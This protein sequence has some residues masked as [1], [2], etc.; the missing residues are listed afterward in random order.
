MREFLNFL[1]PTHIEQVVL[2]AGAWLGAIVSF[3]FGCDAKTI[4]LWL[5]IFIIA[6][7]ASGTIA[8]IKLGQ[9]SSKYGF[10]GIAKK[11]FILGLVALCHGVDILNPAS[12]AISLRD[13]CAFAFSLNELGSI[14]ENI[15][16]MG[17]G[18]M[19]PAPLRKAMAQLQ[20]EQKR[21]ESEK[22]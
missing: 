16:R 10:F 15:G 20:E 11:C 5:A 1:T 4:L 14:F 7:Y 9:W 13:I 22:H 21:E 2:I 3:L 19:I 18:A 8:A 12:E 6:D 17:Y